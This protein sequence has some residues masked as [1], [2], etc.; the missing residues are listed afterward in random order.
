MIQDL[1]PLVKSQTP[2]ILP[3][4]PTTQYNAPEDTVINW[5]VA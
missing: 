5:T 4:S 2:V 3:H 1:R